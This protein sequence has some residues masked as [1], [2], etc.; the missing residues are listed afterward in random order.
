MGQSSSRE[1]IETNYTENLTSLE[2]KRL[3]MVLG[4]KDGLESLSL[5]QMIKNLE[6]IIKV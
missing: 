1:E 2:L 5:K 6:V 3:Q 4:I